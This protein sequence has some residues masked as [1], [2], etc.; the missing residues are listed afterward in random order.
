MIDK[1]SDEE[2]PL[3]PILISVKETNDKL[4]NP[5]KYMQTLLKAHNRLHANLQSFRHT[6]NQ[7]LLELS[8]EIKNRQKLLAHASTTTTKIYTHPNFEL[9]M[10]YVNQVPKYDGFV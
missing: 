6:F 8:M 4:T 9:A 5:R 1:N 10:Q 2:T 7:S 3:L